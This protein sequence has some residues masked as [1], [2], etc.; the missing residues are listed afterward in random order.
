MYC[1]GIV[2]PSRGRN[3][4]RRS[5]YCSQ[6]TGVDSRRSQLLGVSLSLLCFS[7]AY[8]IPISIGKSDPRKILVVNR[9]ISE[10][11]SDHPNELRQTTLLNLDRVVSTINPAPCPSA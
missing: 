5:R 4:G 11:F 8:Q 9:F 1:G 6:G 10:Q 7:V 3:K 2:L